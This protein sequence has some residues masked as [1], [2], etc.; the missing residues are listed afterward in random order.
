M[1]MLDNKYLCLYNFEAKMKIMKMKFLA[2]LCGFLA[3]FNGADAFA[4]N[5]TMDDAVAMVVA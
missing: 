5:L 1:R 3:L 2:V 4:R